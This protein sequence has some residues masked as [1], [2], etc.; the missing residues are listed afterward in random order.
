MTPPPRRELRGAL[1]TGCGQWASVTRKVSQSSVHYLSEAM[2]EKRCRD[3]LRFLAE[4]QACQLVD[5]RI[6]PDG[7]C[8]LA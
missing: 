8:I 2:H 5:G 4:S 6:S 3:C 1:S 7:A